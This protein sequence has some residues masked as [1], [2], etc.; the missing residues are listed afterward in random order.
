VGL[1]QVEGQGQ[2]NSMLGVQ[3]MLGWI[4]KEP[5]ESI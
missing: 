1:E 5:T 4:H 3:L 2:E